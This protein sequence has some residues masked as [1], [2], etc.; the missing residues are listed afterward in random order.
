MAVDRKHPLVTA[1]ESAEARFIWI[2]CARVPDERGDTP[3]QTRVESDVF[4]GIQIQQAAG[5][6]EALEERGCA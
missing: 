6:M 1:K 4:Q 2:C 5:D 3:G